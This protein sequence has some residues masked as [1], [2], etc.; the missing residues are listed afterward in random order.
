MRCIAACKIVK[1]RNQDTH[2]LKILWG[3][4]EAK[5]FQHRLESRLHNTLKLNIEIVPSL[6]LPFKLSW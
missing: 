2:F 4:P 3:F 5:V 6:V 1:Y